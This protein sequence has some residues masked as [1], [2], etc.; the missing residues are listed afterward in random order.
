MQELIKRTADEFFEERV[1]QERVSIESIQDRFYNDFT[2]KFL[3]LLPTLLFKF[4]INKGEGHI[5]EPRP[6]LIEPPSNI[7]WVEKQKGWEKCVVERE[8]EY[9][10]RK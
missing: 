1:V 5:V 9:F 6:L 8:W 4:L 2:E 3:Y 7:N 10:M